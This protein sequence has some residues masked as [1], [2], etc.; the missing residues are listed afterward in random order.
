MVQCTP[1]IRKPDSSHMPRF[2]K[3]ARIS[4][5]G[6]LAGATVKARIAHFISATLDVTSRR[7]DIRLNMVAFVYLLICLFVYLFICV[8]MNEFRKPCEL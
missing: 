7:V 6:S 3:V 1:G 4:S 5:K 8:C 2:T